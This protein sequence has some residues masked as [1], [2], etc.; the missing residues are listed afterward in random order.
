MKVRITNFAKRHFTG[1]SG[2]QIRS[3]SVEN[4]EKYINDI[5]EPFIN[6]PQTTHD[7]NFDEYTKGKEWMNYRLL[8]GYAPFCKLLIAP[9]VTDARTGTA[10]I[11]NEN[12]QWLRTGYYSREEWEL[13]VLTRALHLPMPA[14]KAKYL[15]FVLYKNDHL[16]EEHDERT[17]EQFRQT[18]EKRKKE[19]KDPLNEEDMHSILGIDGVKYEFEDE[20]V[21]WGV[22]SIMGQMINVEE[23][24]PPA[25][26]LRNHLGKKYGGSGV[27]I[28]RDAYLRSVNFWDNHAIIK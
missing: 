8:D 11:T 2:T 18:N 14:E 26:M 25:T 20:D 5:I 24:M 17:K 6:D 23:P 22:V 15:V 27:E 19:G 10:E 16:K 12:Y 9:N 3:L 13:P 7:L 21:E 28:D 4:T 1:R